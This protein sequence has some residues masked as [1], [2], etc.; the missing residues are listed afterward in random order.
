MKRRLTLCMIL[1]FVPLLLF[2]AYLMSQQSFALSLE[3]EMQRVQMLES[4]IRTEAASAFS[5]LSY[6]RMQQVA[7][8]YEQAYTSQQTRL[9]I[10]YNGY[11]LDGVSPD[12][13]AY[14]ALLTGTRSALLNSRSTP[15]EYIIADPITDEVTLLLWKDVSSFYTLRRQMRQTFLLWGLGGGAIVAVLALLIAGWFTEPVRNLTLAARQLSIGIEENSP[16]PL[17]R[18]D[19]LGELAR[20]F[21]G[22]QQAVRIRESALQAE[23]AKQ[24]RLLEAL[25]H[26]MRTPLCSLLGN[27]RLLESAADTRQ[28]VKALADMVH[29][30]KRLTGMDEQLMK[31][32][33]LQHGS[34]EEKPV[35]LLPL[36]AETAR[37]LQPQ[38]D[39]ITLQVQGEDSVL[40][41]DEALLS[42]MTDNLAVNALRAS[43]PG[44][45]VT[46]Q[47]D[48]DGFSVT[49]EGIGMDAGQLAKAFDPFYKGDK[50]RTRNAGGAGLGLSLCKRI[51]ELHGGTL[52]LRSS[53]GAG[54][55]ATFTTLLQPVADS[56]TPLAVSCTQEVD[57]P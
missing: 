38:A 10:L 37:R 55:I 26:E 56:V 43:R 31:L 28:K 17:A 12:G 27:A 8:Q 24:Q 53:H 32:V 25:A 40:Q 35:S 42:L 54:T 11:T 7:S 15:E 13:T 47:A 5:S 50:A 1:C 16:L 9:T 44:Q 52:Q 30:I 33:D 2:F 4:V 19:E 46:L 51:A 45:Q 36:L 57:H 22:M 49:D 34:I 39:G 23:A 6:D 41:G 48:R 20:S 18:K 29:E 14:Q 21:Q 3:Q